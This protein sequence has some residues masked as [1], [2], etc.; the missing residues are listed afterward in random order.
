[1]S[2]K[3]KEI[4]PYIGLSV[5]IV[6]SLVVMG[7]SIINVN[8]STQTWNGWNC[9]Q[10]TWK[11]SRS[12]FGTFPTQSNCQFNCH[13]TTYYCVGM[14]GLCQVE[15]AGLGPYT[16]LSTCNDN[17]I[18]NPAR[19]WCDTMSGQCY[20]NY[21]SEELGF[22]TYSTSQSCESACGQ[23]STCN[24]ATGGSCTNPGDC[25]NP[26][27]ERYE[28]KANL[29]CCKDVA[30]CES[31]SDNNSYGFCWPNSNCAISLGQY[32]CVG[33][34]TCCTKIITPTDTCASKKGTCKDSWLC[35]PLG[36][37]GEL[38]CVGSTKTCCKNPN[39]TTCASFK[40][41]KCVDYR[42]KCPVYYG[43]CN[44]SGSQ[45]CCGFP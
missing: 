4:L 24:S 33:N 23:S 5:I 36:D 14:T 21:T 3:F 20:V 17:C 29:V 6:F 37:W 38:D 16:D 25:S 41:G 45:I 11:C 18:Q 22:P 44:A 42:A 2:P 30:K 12:L 1:M 34:S 40:W 8:P 19:Y 35:S 39:P 28:C 26:A 43:M 13:P 27:S 31:Q 10:T 7:S 15:Q 9:N 32:D